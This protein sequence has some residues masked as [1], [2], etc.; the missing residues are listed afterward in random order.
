MAAFMR[1]VFR[2]MWPFRL[3]WV[4]LW[5]GS[6]AMV[7]WTIGYVTITVLRGITGFDEYW[8]L[9]VGVAIIGLFVFT[10]FTYRDPSPWRAVAITAFVATSVAF[11]TASWFTDPVLVAFRLTVIA[12]MLLG[13]TATVAS[14]RRSD[15]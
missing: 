2:E 7:A 15:A 5:I 10:L 3:I 6:A 1:R 4:L 9:P 12:A 11:A 14:Y 13:I 8:Q